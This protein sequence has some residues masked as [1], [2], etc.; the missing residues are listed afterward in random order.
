[1]G[2]YYLPCDGCFSR[3]LVPFSCAYCDVVHGNV[4]YGWGDIGLSL[5]VGLR[6]FRCIC[7]AMELPFYR[8]IFQHWTN[9]K[10]KLPTDNLQSCQRWQNGLSAT[11]V[12]GRFLQICDMNHTYLLSSRVQ[13]SF[14]KGPTFSF[15]G[16]RRFD[17]SPKDQRQW[18]NHPLAEPTLSQV[19]PCDTSHAWPRWTRSSRT[20]DPENGVLRNKPFMNKPNQTS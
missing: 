15:D 2:G 1:M 17:D 13:V 10:Q 6:G 14:P 19:F 11:F 16:D 20:A 8:I 4:W 5:V 9:S 18:W 7:A 12:L 3:G